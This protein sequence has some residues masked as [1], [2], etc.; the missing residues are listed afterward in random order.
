LKHVEWAL[1]IN[2]RMVMAQNL[3]GIIYE[4]LND[5]KKAIDSYRLALD[6]LSED[7]REKDVDINFNLAVTYFKNNEFD[8]AKEIFEKISKRFIDPARRAEIDQYL[9]L[10][11]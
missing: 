8:K 4:G 2:R 11:K 9:K 1:E 5:L 3:K 6:T 7:A 10:I